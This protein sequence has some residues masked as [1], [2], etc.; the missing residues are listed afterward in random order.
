MTL[1]YDYLFYRIGLV[2]IFAAGFFLVMVTGCQIS[3]TVPTENTP[4][5]VAEAS[6]T[7]RPVT[8]P[9]ARVSPT[10]IAS[11]TPEDNT[12]VLTFWTVESISPEAEGDVGEFMS[13]NLRAFELANADVDVELQLKKA[14]VERGFGAFVGILW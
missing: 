5:P 9:I 2:T 11:V 6:A 1:F 12:I 10:V 14:R 13:S 3:T 8:T 7:A 4:T